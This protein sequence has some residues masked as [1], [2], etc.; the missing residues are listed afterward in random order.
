MHPIR[1]W[2]TGAAL[3]VALCVVLFL[4]GRS[5][6]TSIRVSLSELSARSSIVVRAHVERMQA[7]WTADNTIETTVYLRLSAAPRGHLSA[8]ALIPV[9]VRGG[10]VD[11]LTM[12]SSEAP[13]FEVGEEVFVFLSGPSGSAYEISEGR[14]GKFEVSGDRA[15]NRAWGA[16]FSLVDLEAGARGG[17]WPVETQALSAAGAQ[18]PAVAPEGYVANGQHWPGAHP[19]EETYV[20][21]VNTGDAGGGNGSADAFRNAILAAGNSWSNAGANFAFHY[22]GASGVTSSG[23]DGQNVVHWENMGNSSTLAETTWW[24]SGDQIVEADLRYNDYYTWDATGS[25]SGSE[26]DLQSVTLHE[27][28][29]WLSLGHDTDPGCPNVS[30]VMCATYNLGTTK[31]SLGANDVAGIKAIYGAVQTQPTST[32]TRTA[33]ATYTPTRTPT[34]T[35]TLTPTRT[36]T[37]RPTLAP[38]QVKG[39]VWLPLI[40]R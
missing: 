29:H 3:S 37:P 24:Y 27:L 20:I 31:Q 38:W 26:V 6:A 2:R 16:E 22:G 17:R 13:T 35:R 36:P 40:R 10:M 21:N 32:P 9:R 28:G 14:Q 12:Y 5:D 30:A 7:A 4:A 18:S 33:T 8:G 19:M 34:P 39:R 23:N 1:F 11:D 15:I 25:P